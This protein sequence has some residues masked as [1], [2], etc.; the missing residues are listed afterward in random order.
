MLKVLILKLKIDELRTIRN[1]L[2]YN[3]FNNIRDFQDPTFL[4]STFGTKLYKEYTKKNI[5]TR[6]FQ[7]WF[8][9]MQT[10]LFD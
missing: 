6:P 2:A 1:E 8:A 7:K 9:K 5:R 10:K 4:I 3:V